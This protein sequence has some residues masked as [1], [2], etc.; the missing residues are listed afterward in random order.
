[1]SRALRRRSRTR[2][3][4][5]L[6]LSAFAIAALPRAFVLCV[7]QDDHVRVE[8]GLELVPCQPVLSSST[9]PA[10]EVPG[11]TCTDFP[12]IGRVAR[13][14]EG[15]EIAALE[16][17]FIAV[18]WVANALIPAPSRLPRPRSAEPIPYATL[19]SIRTT[20]LLI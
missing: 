6:L 2:A 10:A 12:A 3:L 14:A 9:D 8:A 16:L 1:M 19:A 13:L 11:E 15:G 20:V 7:S 4:L 5:L 18:D 17:A